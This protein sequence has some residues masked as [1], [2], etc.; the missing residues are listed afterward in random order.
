VSLAAGVALVTPIVFVGLD[1]IVGAILG[2]LDVARPA[3][4]IVVLDAFSIHVDPAVVVGPAALASAVSVIGA[5]RYGAAWLR[6]RGPIEL[7]FKAGGLT[8]AAVAGLAIVLA[9][10]WEFLQEGLATDSPVAIGASVLAF[11]AAVWIARRSVLS[12]RSGRRSPE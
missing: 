8:L 11:V 12:F 10:S 9:L 2:L 1:A 5:A 7:L 3:Y 6:V 4:T